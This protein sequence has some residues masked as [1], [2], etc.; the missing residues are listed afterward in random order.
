MPDDAQCEVLSMVS[1][2]PANDVF[3][4][5]A[6]A[7]VLAIFALIVLS[8][9]IAADNGTAAI[10]APAVDSVLI[11]SNG[12]ALVSSSANLSVPAAGNMKIRLANFSTSAILG[13]IKAEDQDAG[14]YWLKRYSEEKAFTNKTERYLSIDELLNQSYGKRIKAATKDGNISGTLRW[15]QN[16]RIGIESN[17][18]LFVMTAEPDK[19]EV[20]YQETKRTDE[21]NSTSLETGLELYMDANRQGAHTVLLDYIS[22]GASWVPSYRFEMGSPLT[23][24]GRLFASAEVANNGDQ[25]WN[26]TKLRLA[27]GSPYFV[28]ASSA[29][30]DNYYSAKEMAAPSTAGAA[31]RAPSFSGESSGTQYVYTFSEPVS[32]LK[33]ESANLQ[34]FNSQAEYGKYNLWQGYGDVQ[35]M[36]KITNNAGKP[37]A[38]GIIRIYE[39]GT[40]AGEASMD[41][42]GEGKQAEVAYAALPQITVKKEGNQT[43]GK[44]STDRTET[45]YNV[46][47]KVESSAKGA[48][49]LTLRDY[50]NYGDQVELLSSSIPAAQLSG[51]QLEWKVSVPAGANLTISYSYKT[52]NFQNQYVY[53]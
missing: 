32:L 51:N 16:G 24:S 22:T 26:S 49:P 17:G 39:A 33:Y 20:P 12:F 31:A 10:P 41:Y 37:L 8:P 6:A 36:V 14:I 29:Y 25:D 5:P 13:T 47:M 48:M 21:V 45:L 34:L 43:T 52:V 19:I 40:F 9:C 28:S 53:G 35:Q 18:T 38:S 44:P 42:T 4:F 11:Y 30:Y 2:K 46:T 3:K 7:A 50:M 1:K 27:I 15:V 23:G